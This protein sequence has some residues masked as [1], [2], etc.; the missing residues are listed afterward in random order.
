VG[1]RDALE[2][3]DAVARDPKPQERAGPVE[4]DEVDAIGPDVLADR[5]E[6]RVGV[7][8]GA[9]LIREV[10]VGPLVRVAAGARSVQHE[11]REAWCP[12]RQVTQ[13]VV[14]VATEWRCHRVMVT[15]KPPSAIR[16]LTDM[17]VPMAGT[18]RRIGLTVFAGRPIGLAGS[19][20]VCAGPGTIT[21]S[22]AARRVV[23]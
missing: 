5:G 16:A 4:I 2:D 11:Q 20:Y 19:K 14:R 3:D 12:G 10:P 9:G 23:P 21:S 8:V 13:T 18:T 17:R 6:Q 1:A 22:R 15:R 7:E